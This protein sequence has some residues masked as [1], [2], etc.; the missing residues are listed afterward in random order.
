VRRWLGITLAAILILVVGGAVAIHALSGAGPIPPATV[1]FAALGDEERA[2]LVVRGRYVARAADCEACH[3]SPDGL[4]YAGGLAMETPFGTIYGTNITPSKEH[5]IGGWSADDLYRSMVYGIMP[6]GTRLYPAMPYTSYH[7]TTRADVDALWAYLMS[8][9]PVAKPDRP[10]E[11]MF[12]FNIR[13]AIA[14]WNLVFRPAE[15]ELA[16][17]D[18]RTEDWHRGRYLV[19]VLGHC[20]ECHTPR[21]L[22]YAM[23]EG[24][25]LKGEVIEGA[26]APDITPEGLAERGWTPED[27]KRFMAVGLSP[28]GTMTFRMYPVLNHSTKYLTEQDLRAM[29]GYLMDGVGPLETKPVPAGDT[30]GAD[31]EAG[32][33]LYVGLCAGCHGTEG[34]GHPH[35][36]VPLDTNTT[37]M[38]EDPINLVK[39]IRDG[40]PARRL[41][42]EERMQEM[43]A[44]GSRL[45]ADEMAALVNYMRATWGARPADVTPGQVA[46]IDDR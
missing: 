5:G 40:V 30:A 24:E 9:P 35:A 22:A 34:E 7:F 37:A 42:D 33:A 29:V 31:L 4:S 44:F 16:P 45:D 14:V 6:D 46:E 21:N 17:V 32:R 39:I 25:H 43:P 15:T 3:K 12:P 2:E 8:R 10:A 28:Q 19:D 27:L 13:P 38:L 23:I 41:A 11:M 20:G 36:S 26:L 1:D 18:G